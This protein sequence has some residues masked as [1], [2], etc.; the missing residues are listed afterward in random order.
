MH[1]ARV[2]C[3]PLDLC[4]SRS[5]CLYRARTL[6]HG[7]AVAHVH[8]LFSVVCGSILIESVNVCSSDVCA[9]LSAA[10]V[11]VSLSLVSRCCLFWQF[12]VHRA[13]PFCT[14]C[15]AVVFDAVTSAL[16]AAFPKLDRGELDSVDSVDSTDRRIFYV[17]GPGG[18]GKS[19]LFEALLAWTR[20]RGGIAVPCAWSGLAATLLP[21]GRT[22]HS[23]FGLPVPL[24]PAEVSL[25]VTARSGRGAVLQSAV[26]ILWDECSMAPAVAVDAVDR[27]LRDLCFCDEPFGGKVVV[28]GGD[29]RQTLPVLPREGREGQLAACIFSSV[30]FREGRVRRFR[31]QCNM[32]AV[33]SSEFP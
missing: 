32:R 33:A 14:P 7:S 12:A 29:P 19:F 21:G 2:A 6:A 20:A 27:H 24:P 10:A 5:P 9:C 18:A 26:L 22:C 25:T 1:P 23:T 16:R 4:L 13:H 11:C 17:D 15:E 3:I 8:P 30:P 31:L 28:F